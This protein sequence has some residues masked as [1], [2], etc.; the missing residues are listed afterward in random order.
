MGGGGGVGFPLILSRIKWISK[1]LFPQTKD[2][3]ARREK[4]AIFPSLTWGWRGGGG[5]RRGVL[6][7]HL[8][9]PRS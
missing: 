2:E 8:F 3:A 4:R 1:P 9:C 5:E 6:V 7:F